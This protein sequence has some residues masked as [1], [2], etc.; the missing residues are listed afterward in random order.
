[1]EI[2]L[3]RHT[4]PDI[5]KEICY[6]QSDVLL[7]GNFPE[8]AKAVLQQLPDKIDAVYTSPLDRCKALAKMIPSPKLTEAAEMMEMNFGDWELRP[9]S[10]IDQEELDPWMADFVHHQ[11]P[12]GESMQLL[13]NRVN[14]W[15]QNLL[16]ST[17]TR[18]VVVCHA[19]PI[20][21]LL[22][23][24]NHTRLEEAFQRYS[25]AYG[26]VKRVEVPGS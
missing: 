12:N 3:V 2:Y 16:Q 22:S 25:V 11:V 9:W 15:Y 26:E 8:E 14:T 1:M 20:R 18:V 17:D 24:I 7:S 23:L 4:T 5:A 13:V 6:G 19:G 21:V 10:A